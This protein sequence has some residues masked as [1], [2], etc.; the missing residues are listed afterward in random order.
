MLSTLA[1]GLTHP[2]RVKEEF[3]DRA[4]IWQT[5]PSSFTKHISAA[6]VIDS[7]PRKRSLREEQQMVLSIRTLWLQR[8]KTPD[9]G[10][11]CTLKVLF[12]KAANFQNRTKYW[13]IDFLHSARKSWM[14]VCL[15]STY[16]NPKVLFA[17]IRFEMKTK[18]TEFLDCV[19]IVLFF[20]PLIKSCITLHKILCIFNSDGEPKWC[21]QSWMI[22]KIDWHRD[23]W[24]KIHGAGSSAADCAESA[25][26]ASRA[27]MKHFC[28]SKC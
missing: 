8:H 27:R 9:R 6:K 19:V 16:G 20:P 3:L 5:A 14:L 12:I 26:A 23:Y 1:V 10:V 18:T 25:K 15:K 4:S 2:L 24:G 22:N 7:L 13:L 17:F 21:T 28:S 11:H